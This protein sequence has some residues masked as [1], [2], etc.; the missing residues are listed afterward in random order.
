MCG[1]TGIWEY[2]ASEGGVTL[3][4]VERMRDTMPHRGP[5]AFGA[6]LFDGGRGGFGFRRL[7]I[8]DLS[9]AGNQPMR[10]CP[11]REILLVFNGEIY[12][13]NDLRIGLEARGHKYHSRTDSETILHSYEEQGL[14]L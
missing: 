6:Q 4:I 9:E 8:I 7:S 10:G 14:I 13:H 12:N 1:I 2:G 11:D 5:D 3:P